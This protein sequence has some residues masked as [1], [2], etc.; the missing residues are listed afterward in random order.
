MQTVFHVSSPESDVRRHAMVNVTNLLEDD[1]TA[2]P[3]D[4]VAI[5][6]NG[7][8]V[9]MFVASTAANGE[10]VASLVERGVECFAC[11]ASLAKMNAITADLLPGV[12]R[13]QSGVGALAR[14]QDEGYG[15]VKAP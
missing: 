2:A 14:L 8:G 10:L 3:D 4:D 12:E 7:A 15:Y 11:G 13:V 5:V 6:A 9:R 1:T